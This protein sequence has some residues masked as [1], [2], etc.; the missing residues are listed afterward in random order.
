MQKKVE[1]CFG[2]WLPRDPEIG[3]YT[4]PDFEVKTRYY[5]VNVNA[6]VSNS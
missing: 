1:Y 2:A 5:A 3:A 6:K 4:L